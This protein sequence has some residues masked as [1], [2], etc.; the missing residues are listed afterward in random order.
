MKHLKKRKANKTQKPSDEMPHTLYPLYSSDGKRLLCPC[1]CRLRI[2]ILRRTHDG[3]LRTLCPDRC[4]AEKEPS[5]AVITKES[6][7]RQPG[8]ECPGPS[9]QNVG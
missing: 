1:V 3:N 4:E 6:L 2:Y 9:H 8:T 7:R 5:A